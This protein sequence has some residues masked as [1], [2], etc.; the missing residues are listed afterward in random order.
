MVGRVRRRRW[1]MWRWRRAA[2]IRVR[3][4]LLAA[5]LVGVTTPTVRLRTR[6]VRSLRCR[7]GVLI[8]AR[9]ALAVRCR[10]GAM[11][12]MTARRRRRVRSLRCRWVLI[13]GARWT[14]TTRWSAGARMRSGSPRFRRVW[15]RPMRCLRGRITRARC[16]LTIRWNAGG[17]PS[18][19]RPMRRR[20]RLRTLVRVRSTRAVSS[21]A[22]AWCVGARTRWAR[23]HRGRW[24]LLRRW[25]LVGSIRARRARRACR[26]GAAMTRA[27]GSRSRDRLCRCRLAGSIRVRCPNRLQ[28]RLG[29]RCRAGGWTPAVRRPFRRRCSPMCLRAGSIRAR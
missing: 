5:L 7:W 19:G 21:P 22:G 10:A 23:R 16:W 12:T 3:S 8:R 9:S 13:M 18:S 28:A 11:R 4:L 20:A 15:A 26:A 2:R 27:R 24:A 25:V 6:R 14:R 17:S 29:E 1:V